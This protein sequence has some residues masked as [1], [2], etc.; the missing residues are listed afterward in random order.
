ML[1][2][3]GG[4]S[5]TSPTANASGRNTQMGRTIVHSP[6][7]NYESRKQK[8]INLKQMLVSRINNFLPTNKHEYNEKRFQ[9]SSIKEMQNAIGRGRH[10]QMAR[11]TQTKLL[12]D[13]KDSQNSVYEEVLD[14]SK[15]IQF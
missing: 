1:E 9:N 11:S 7:G 14:K 15:S 4:N 2:S 10:V 3:A 5:F 8:D 12:K 13:F 6:M